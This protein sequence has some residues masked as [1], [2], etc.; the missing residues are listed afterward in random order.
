M[1][2]VR[3][4]SLLLFSIAQSDVSSA[5]E[6]LGM[7]LGTETR[8]AM[9][10]H[11]YRNEHEKDNVPFDLVAELPSL[12]CR[13]HRRVAEDRGAGYSTAKE[14]VRRIAGRRSRD[15]RW[16]HVVMVL[17]PR[18]AVIAGCCGSV[19]KVM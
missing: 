18:F 19:S 12:R 4:E 7:P 17:R 1:V 16:S 11:E 5:P 6:L 15:S 14:R 10:V 3:R 13:E 8:A 2:F 9:R